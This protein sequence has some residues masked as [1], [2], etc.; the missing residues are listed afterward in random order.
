MLEH[1]VGQQS[2]ATWSWWVMFGTGV[3]VA[4]AQEEIE[5]WCQVA[6]PTAYHTDPASLSLN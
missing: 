2:Q 3:A 4:S 5:R 6:L 1:S